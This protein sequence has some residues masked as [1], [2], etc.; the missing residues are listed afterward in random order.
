[1]ELRRQRRNDYLAA[2]AEG[3]AIKLSYSANLQQFSKIFYI[4]CQILDVE[5]SHVYQLTIYSKFAIW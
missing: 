3:C 4:A 5:G 2:T 1:M